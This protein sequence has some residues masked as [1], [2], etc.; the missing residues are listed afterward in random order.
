MSDVYQ[1][2][3]DLNRMILDG[4]AIEAFEKYYADDVVMQEG[5]EEPIVGKAE[6]RAREE[7]FFSKI[8]A[9]RGATV[10]AVAVG[11][12]VST[13]EWNWDYSHVDWGD[14]DFDQ[15]AVQRWRDGKIVHERFYKAP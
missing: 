5:D 7:E 10:K 8:T 11:D 1:A 15:V 3:T 9:F 2:V 12:N 4:K 6:N 13:V 14:L